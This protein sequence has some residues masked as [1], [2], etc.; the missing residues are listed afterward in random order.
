MSNNINDS[1]FYVQLLSNAFISDF[2]LP[3]NVQQIPMTPH[4]SFLVLFLFFF[5]FFFILGRAVDY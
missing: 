5:I 4:F 3:S 2:L 1:H